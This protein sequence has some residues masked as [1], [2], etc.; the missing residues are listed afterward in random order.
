MRYFNILARQTIFRESTRDRTSSR[1]RN[2]PLAEVVAALTNVGNGIRT[3]QDGPAL[4]LGIGGQ[5][6]GRRPCKNSVWNV[7]YQNY[8]LLAFRVCGSLGV[9]KIA[10]FRVYGLKIIKL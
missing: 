2:H 5:L 9:H 1:R 10:W 7:C 4:A 6:S 8:T 3:I